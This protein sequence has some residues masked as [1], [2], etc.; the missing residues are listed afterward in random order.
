MAISAATSLG[1][2]ITTGTVVIPGSCRG[3]WTDIISNIEASAES[4]G[5]LLRPLSAT[6]SY[7][8]P[9]Q[10]VVGTRIKFR[11]KYTAGATVG[12]NP[13]VRI[14]AMC[15]SLTNAGL[16]NDDGT[17]FTERIDNADANAA[18]LTI[19]SAT[20]S[21]LRDTAYEYTDTY[22]ADLTAYDL[23][24]AWYVFALIETAAAITAGVG[25]LQAQAL[26]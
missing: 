3:Q 13:V 20:G 4:A 15:G 21:Q 9:A 7:I 6:S 24:G 2:P 10:V 8:V 19:T 22:P 25:T 1:T 17:V 16:F 23:Q 12:T 26:N 18:G 14:Y 5:V 11:M